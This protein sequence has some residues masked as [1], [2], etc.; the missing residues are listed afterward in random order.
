LEEKYGWKKI[1]YRE[2]HHV[3]RFQKLQA[4]SRHRSRADE[5]IE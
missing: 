4:V 3:E 1:V 2:R 5:V